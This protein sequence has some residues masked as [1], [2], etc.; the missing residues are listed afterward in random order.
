MKTRSVR[1]SFLLVAALCA[2]PG[3]A[4]DSDWLVRADEAVRT[5]SFDATMVRHRGNHMHV[6]RIQQIHDETGLRQRVQTDRRG[7][8]LEIKATADD[9]SAMGHPG[10]FR[11]LPRSRGDSGGG[12]KTLARHYQARLG[13][14]EMVAGRPC[15]VVEF[16]SRDEYRYGCDLCL[17]MAS[18][19]PLRLRMHKGETE[20]AEQY[21]IASLKVM[22]S[23]EDFQPDTFRDC[24][25]PQPGKR[26]RIVAST[27]AWEVEALPPGFSVRKSMVRT[28]RKSGNLVHHLVIADPMS[29]IS[30]FV[31]PKTGVQMEEPPRSR[32]IRHAYVTDRG[33]HRIMVLGVVPDSTKRMIG[34]SIR[35]RR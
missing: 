17:D 13:A 25:K 4:A 18:G 20:P 22:D 32:W 8:C 28:G 19:L 24:G 33:E 11:L 10:L 14:Q 16:E 23:A 1:T 26:S 2:P 3:L 35:L 15:Q 5:L 7:R 29:Q 34:D 21:V 9:K 30:V 27:S 12:M 6:M 31:V